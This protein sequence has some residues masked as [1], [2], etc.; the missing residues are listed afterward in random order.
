MK[1]SERA[2]EETKNG[3]KRFNLTL[4]TERDAT[5]VEDFK[6]ICRLQKKRYTKVILD[7]IEDYIA[8]YKA[9][10]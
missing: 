1:D 10:R 8:D 4:Y 2:N 5:L 9:T 6:K 3:K 7:L